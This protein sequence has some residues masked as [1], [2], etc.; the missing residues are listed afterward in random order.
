MRSLLPPAASHA[1]ARSFFILPAGQ[2]GRD[3]GLRARFVDRPTDPST[4]HGLM[5]RG[6]ELASWVG[7]AAI[8]HARMEREILTLSLSLSLS[9]CLLLSLSLSLSLSLPPSLSHT[10]THTHIGARTFCGNT[11]VRLFCVAHLQE[12]FFLTERKNV[13]PEEGTEQ[14]TAGERKSVRCVRASSSKR[15]REEEE[16]TEGGRAG[17]ER[18]REIDK[19]ISV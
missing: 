19:G 8:T 1:S 4:V 13:R 2:S 9:V 11:D 18:A 15:T 3:K 5:C 10:H 7:S 12:F 17:R 16:G 14:T 6:R